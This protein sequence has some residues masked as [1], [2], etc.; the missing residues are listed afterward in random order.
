VKDRISEGPDLSICCPL[1]MWVKM[2]AVIDPT[3]A[4]GPVLQARDCGILQML[5]VL[6][7]LPPVMCG[8]RKKPFVVDAVQ[9]DQD[10]KVRFQSRAKRCLAPGGADLSRKKKTSARM[11]AVSAPDLACKP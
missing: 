9:G 8:E 10:E 6:S 3:Q 1:G 5:Q 2:V 11:S 7:N 4:C